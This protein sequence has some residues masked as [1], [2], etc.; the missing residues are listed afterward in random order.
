MQELSEKILSEYQVRK[1]KE[2]KTAF[3][4]LLKQYY[5]EF[6][7]K[8]E[9]TFYPSDQLNFPVHMAIS[10]MNRK[11]FVGFY[12]DKIHTKHDVVFDRTNIECI[13]NGIQTF[14]SKLDKRAA[15]NS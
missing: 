14:I 13:C 9:T 5:P 8:A 7:E 12:M 1:T 6:F 4:E 2:Q 15:S 10:S 3:I 11:P